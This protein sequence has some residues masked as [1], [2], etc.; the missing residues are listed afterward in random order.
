MPD[1]SFDARFGAMIRAISE[2]GDWSGPAIAQRLVP[3][4]DTDLSLLSNI[5]PRIIAELETHPTRDSFLTF[6]ANDPELRTSARK[7]FRKQL[8]KS[9]RIRIP[10]MKP[11]FDW[12][13]PRISTSGELADW[14]SL[15]RKQLDWFADLKGINPLHDASR[16][17]H[18]HRSWIAKS[19]NRFRLLE[20]PKAR[21]KALQRRI[22]HEMLDRIPPHE[23]AHGFRRG[24]SIL[25]FVQPHLG[26]EIVWRLDLKDFFPLIPASRVRA[27]FRRLGYSADVSQL[28][29]GLCTTRTPPGLLAGREADRHPY[30]RRHLP[31]GSPTSP[32]IANLCAYRLDLR[33]SS[34]CRACGVNYTRYADD[35]AFSGGPELRRAGSAFRVAVMAIVLEEGFRPNATK[36]R[37]MTA[38][39]R[40]RLTGL[41]VN[42]KP[43]L[44]RGEFDRLKAIL[45]NSV[46]HGLESQ[47]R[48]GHADFRAH[49]QGRI[50]HAETVNPDRGTKLRAIYD[51]IVDIG[52][53]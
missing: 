5:I 12:D 53:T 14:L 28:L 30:L 39:T 34:Y 4:F 23:A 2:V 43:N 19:G 38:S 18:Y 52:T 46:R 7:G 45:T 6:L 27:L 40:Q 29:A 47:N 21:L 25:S 24:R 31:Q 13:I 8:P 41:I 11:L 26:R 49:L 15:P 17:D 48:D 50:A 16:I 22:L 35:L 37:W 44:P 1:R 51:R 36:S 20:S 10:Q 42:R 9:K 32:A 3:F 33:L